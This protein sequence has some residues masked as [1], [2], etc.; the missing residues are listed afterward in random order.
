MSSWGLFK[1]WPSLQEEKQHQ[2]RSTL[3]VTTIPATTINTTQTLYH[4]LQTPLLP[5]FHQHFDQR[6]LGFSF[7]VATSWRLSV[8]LTLN[9]KLWNLS[10]EC[11][12]WYKVSNFWQ[13]KICGQQSRKITPEISLRLLKCLQNCKKLPPNQITIFVIYIINFP[14]FEISDVLKIDDKDYAITFSLYFRY[15]LGIKYN[16]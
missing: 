8:K 7:S 4:R 12:K 13:N 1:I 5:H 11:W 6:S 3:T 9:G 10:P 16:S 14:G 15:D 2:N